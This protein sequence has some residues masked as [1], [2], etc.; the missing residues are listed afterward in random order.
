MSVERKVKIRRIKRQIKAVA[1]IGLAL[2]AGAF[3][4]CVPRSRE[5][6]PDPSQP[7]LPP[8]HD[9]ESPVATVDATIDGNPADVAIE[10]A[11]GKPKDASIDRRQHR[12]GM[13]VPD[14]LLE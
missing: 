9:I 6:A 5:I 11:E 10:E 7:P 14:N 13:P 3:L 2:A 1:S 4:T 8:P 12:K